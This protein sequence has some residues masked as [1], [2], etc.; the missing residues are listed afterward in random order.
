MIWNVMLASLA[1]GMICLDRVFAQVMIS[2]PVVAGPLVGWLLDDLY[3]GLLCGALIELL[4]IDRLPIGKYVPPNGTMTTV[5]VTAAAILAGGHLG[6]SSRELTVFALLAFL[7]LGYAGQQLD[8][9]IIRSNDKLAKKAVALVDEP[10]VRAIEKLHIEALLK[11]F[12]FSVLFIFIGI[13]LG[14]WLLAGAFALLPQFVRKALTL[15]YFFIPLLGIAVALTTIKR[16]GAVSLFCAIYVVA[17][18]IWEWTYGF[19]G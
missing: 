6:Q 7:P 4:W 13:L 2:R 9:R 15:S 19:P 11:S 5:I 3:T 12:C 10:N 8:I 18:M 17:I 16:K 1:G 14:S